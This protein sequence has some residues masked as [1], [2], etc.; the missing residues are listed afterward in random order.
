MDKEAITKRIIMIHLNSIKKEVERIIESDEY[1][2]QAKAIKV[3]YQINTLQPKIYQA[4]LNFEKY[5]DQDED[6]SQLH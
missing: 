6:T 5:L 3:I 1:D 2:N 4:L